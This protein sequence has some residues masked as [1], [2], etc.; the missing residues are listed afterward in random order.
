MTISFSTKNGK[1]GKEEKNNNTKTK[2]RGQS[3]V[4]K[5]WGF[6]VLEGV[7]GRIGG[8]VGRYNFVS[9]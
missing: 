1:N 5:K 6:M 7:G 2:A 9:T 8:G 4:N 3:A